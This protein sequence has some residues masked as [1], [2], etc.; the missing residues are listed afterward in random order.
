MSELEFYRLA[1][2]VIAGV[3]LTLVGLIYR[4][5]VRRLDRL[6]RRFTFFV[7][8]FVRW[9]VDTNPGAAATTAEAFSKLFNGRID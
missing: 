4:E 1:I 7:Q 9:A 8:V 2:G 3:M 6:D 5:N